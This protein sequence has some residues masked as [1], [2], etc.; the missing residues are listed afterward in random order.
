MDKALSEVI[1]EIETAIS[2]EKEIASPRKEFFELFLKLAK[3][4][5]DF[6]QGIRQEFEKNFYTEQ[7]I[8][9]FTTLV[10]SD[11]VEDPE[12]NTWHPISKFNNLDE[13]HMI[14]AFK[15][16]APFLLESCYFDKD[17]NE[18][19]QFVTENRTFEGKLTDEK[20]QEYPFKFKLEHNKQYKIIEKELYQVFSANNLPWRT[21]NSPFIRKIF[22]VVVI[23]FPD[24]GASIKQIEKLDL[25]FGDDFSPYIK[26]NL[27][28]VWNIKRDSKTRRYEKTLQIPCGNSLFYKYEA[29]PVT[30]S[31]V[32]LK[33]PDID[34]E[35]LQV[36]DGR[37]FALSKTRV[38]AIKWE[39][40]EISDVSVSSLNHIDKQ[41]KNFPVFSNRQVLL[42]FGN[43]YRG[44]ALRT[45]AGVRGLINSFEALQEEF[46]LTK[47]ELQEAHSD[48][49]FGENLNEFINLDLIPYDIRK[50]LVVHLKTRNKRNQFTFDLVQF[51]ISQLQLEFPEFRLEAKLE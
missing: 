13:G 14:K 24:S 12:Q 23:D 29:L 27:V 9:I 20:N 8:D 28:P 44:H 10:S 38:N 32:L 42:P 51:M 3:N 19:E 25:I 30:S 18:L 45:E 5:K 17:Y 2:S 6:Q 48:G 33:S 49:F 26:R 47:I 41:N 43:L 31:K 1:K 15:G 4:Q 46:E 34:I 35:G 39:W 7:P 50:T 22:D 21:L 16:G 40:F 37:V 36:D 11:F